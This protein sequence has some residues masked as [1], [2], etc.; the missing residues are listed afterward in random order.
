MERYSVLI[1]METVW[2]QQ[3]IYIYIYIHI[4]QRDIAESPEIYPCIDGQ[5]TYDKGAGVNNGKR[6]VSSQYG[7]EKTGQ[8]L[9][10][11]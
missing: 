7:T 8:S 2:C 6:A 10:S 3:K 1:A 9:T 4:G 11:E 5:L